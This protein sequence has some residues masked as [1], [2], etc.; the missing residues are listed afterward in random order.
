ML[1]QSDVHGHHWHTVRCVICGREFSV[2]WSLPYPEIPRC[3]GHRW[4]KRKRG[5]TL[6]QLELLG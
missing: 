3:L 6:L 1:V 2:H 5:V 4:R